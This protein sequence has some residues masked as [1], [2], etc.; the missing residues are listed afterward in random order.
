MD[1][2]IRQLHGWLDSFFV[3]DPQMSA[4]VGLGSDAIQILQERIIQSPIQGI[5]RI[6]AAIIL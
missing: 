2:A 6:L 5:G 1:S 4:S 3:G